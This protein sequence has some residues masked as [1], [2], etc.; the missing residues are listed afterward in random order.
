LDWQQDDKKSLLNITQNKET[1]I[2]FSLEV[3]INYTDGSSEIKKMDIIKKE[4]VVSFEVQKKVLSM[5]WDPEV[6]LL[7]EVAE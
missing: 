7:F 6:T 3:A 1:S 5:D 4:E 2:Y